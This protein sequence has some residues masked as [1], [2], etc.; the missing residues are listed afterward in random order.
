MLPEAVHWHSLALSSSG[1]AVMVQDFKSGSNR[2]LNLILDR[3]TV[4]MRQPENAAIMMQP[5]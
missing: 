4:A 3:A 5:S 1:W 2:D